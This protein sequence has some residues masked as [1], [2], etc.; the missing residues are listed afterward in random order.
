MIVG[1]EVAE[2]ASSHNWLYMSTPVC[3]SLVLTV[4]SNK[5]ATVLGSTVASGQLRLENI[6]LMEVTF[7]V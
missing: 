3:Q 7:G 2:K 1:S 4:L 5:R 6:Y